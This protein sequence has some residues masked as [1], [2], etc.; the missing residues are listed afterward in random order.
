[1][2]RGKTVPAL[3]GKYVFGDYVSGRLF[4]LETR[5]GKAVQNSIIA[6]GV[7]QISAFGTDQSNELYICDHGSGKILEAGQAI[8]ALSGSATD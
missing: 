4:A 6:E 7:G 5:D 3:E 1:M 2:Y 8:A